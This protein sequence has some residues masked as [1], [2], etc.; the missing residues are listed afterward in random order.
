MYEVK[1]K[2]PLLILPNLPE[3][4]ENVPEGIDEN[5]KSE[6]LKV[7][8]LLKTAVSETANAV[9]ENGS[10]VI[11]Y[12]PCLFELAD[13]DS[14]LFENFDDIFLNNELDMMMTT[15]RNQLHGTEDLP[16]LDA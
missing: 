12:N 6:I 2:E 7:E 9:N 8:D 1:E 14:Q 16:S 15:D 10:D 3:D 4:G 11:S 5:A 13:D